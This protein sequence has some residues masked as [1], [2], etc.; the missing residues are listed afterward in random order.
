MS[1]PIAVPP[2]DSSV[3]RPVAG[4]AIAACALAILFV[5]IVVIG[6]VVSF[7]RGSPLLLPEWLLATPAAG[8]VLGYIAVRHIRNSEGTRA[9][10]KLAQYSLWLSAVSGLTYFVYV[11]AVGLAVT[12]Q[13]NDFLMKL[14]KDG[15]FF[16]RLK[17]AKADPVELKQAF[18]LALSPIQRQ[19]ADPTNEAEWRKQFGEP[20]PDGTPSP[21]AAF[22][23]MKVIALLVFH[24]ANVTIEPLAVQDWKFVEGAY[25]V[26]RAYRVTTP[27]ATSDY[28]VKVRSHEALEPG[29]RRKW[30]MIPQFFQ[31]TPPKLTTLGE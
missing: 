11:K 14:D 28:L 10:L 8:F 20:G 29:E 12:Q 25:V 24:G 5:L 16:P 18:L 2:T 6:T 4:L 15:G 22:G 9:G 19:T 30:I 17:S 7:F 23:E 13:A 31:V 3:Y 27:E 21:W 1:D 26:S